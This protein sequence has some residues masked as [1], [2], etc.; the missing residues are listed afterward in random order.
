MND[1]KW[2]RALSVIQSVDGYNPRF[3]VKCVQDPA[4]HVP[5]WETSFPWHVPTPVAI[6]WLE[7]DPLGVASTTKAH[8][9]TNELVGGLERARIPHVL[10]HG[11]IRI[12]GYTRPGMGEAT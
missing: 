8:D 3:R 4:S 10:V 12:V 2:R 7:L 11:A 5:A 1:T 6:E 9:H